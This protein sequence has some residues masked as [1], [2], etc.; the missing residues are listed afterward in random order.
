MKNLETYEQYLFINRIQGN[1]KVNVIELS[2]E[3]EK[4]TFIN[5]E[6]GN[7]DASSLSFLWAGIRTLKI[8]AI[9]EKLSLQHMPKSVTDLSLFFVGW[10]MTCV[11]TLFVEKG[12]QRKIAH[13]ALEKFT[14]EQGEIIL[15]YF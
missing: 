14:P 13:I 6:L 1:L 5:K 8:Y 15:Q 3:Q 9:E 10:D 11:D 12:C 7:L 4:I 2:L